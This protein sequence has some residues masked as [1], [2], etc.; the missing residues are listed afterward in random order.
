MSKKNE[1]KQRARAL[2][3]ADVELAK[4]ASAYRDLPPVKAAGW[5]AQLADQPP[6]LAGSAVVALAGLALRRGRLARTGMRMLASELVATAIKGRIK[7]RLDRTRPGKMLNDGRYAF[8]EAQGEESD[9]AWS[10]FPSGHTAGAVAV[11]RAIAREYPASAPAGAAAATLVGAAQL[12][13]A[14]HFPSDVAAGAVIGWVA[15]ELVHLGERA[16]MRLI[17]RQA[18]A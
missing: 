14:A 10:S 16:A 7:K 8:R 9:G 11:G 13:T 1:A 2:E 3:R 15:E 17:A 4:R 12:P 5:L 6:L 18:G